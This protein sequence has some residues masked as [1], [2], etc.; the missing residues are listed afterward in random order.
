MN[1]ER[2]LKIELSE[3]LL[4]IELS[5]RLFCGVI[6]TLVVGWRTGMGRKMKT[7]DM[8]QT[9]RKNFTQ[10]PGNL[11]HIVRDSSRISCALLL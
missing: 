2:L 10:L 8:R 1:A 7:D 6:T 5:E 4:K 11:C 3:R 9:K